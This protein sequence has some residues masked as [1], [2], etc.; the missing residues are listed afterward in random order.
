MGTQVTVYGP[1][2]LKPELDL[3]YIGGSPWVSL[4]Y[5]VAAYGAWSYT[6]IVP[7]Y[8]CTNVGTTYPNHLFI[9]WSS[10]TV[11]TAYGSQ[12]VGTFTVICAQPAATASP[13]PTPT[14]SPKPTPTKSP[15]PR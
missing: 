1:Y 13:N 9:N 5:A 10:A 11:G 7:Q 8:P 3:N 2:I 12:D 15:K 14:A 6:F 4:H